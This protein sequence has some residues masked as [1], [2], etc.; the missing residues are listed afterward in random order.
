[1]NLRIVS[2]LFLLSGIFTAC[3][4]KSGLKSG[5]IILTDKEAFGKVIE[6]KGEK[7]LTDSMMDPRVRG[8]L[9]KDGKLIC[10]YEADPPFL[11][12]NAPS[13]KFEGYKGR[14]GNGPNEFV[15]PRLV[16]ASELDLLCY[17]YELTNQKVYILDNRYNIKPYPI[18]LSELF[19]DNRLTNNQLFNIRKDDFMFIKMLYNGISIFRIAKNG[20]SFQAK[21]LHS[22]NL[23]PEESYESIV[24][25]IEIIR[26]KY[27]EYYDNYVNYNAVLHN[28]SSFGEVFSFI[29]ENFGKEPRI[30]ELNTNAIVAGKEKEFYE[31]FISKSESYD[32]ST[33]AKEPENEIFNDSK[34]IIFDGFI[35]CFCGNSFDSFKDLFFYKKA[36]NYIPTG[37]CQPFQRKIFLTVNGK[38]LPCEKIG[39]DLPLGYVSDEKVIIDVEQVASI[40]SEMYSNIVNQC[41]SCFLWRNCGKCIYFMK[42]ENGKLKC[43]YFS[44]TNYA[45]SY[46]SNNISYAEENPIIYEKLY[47]EVIND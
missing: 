26:N 46:L 39:H 31:M 29:T 45:S 15:L 25:N 5:E 3:H 30:A 11:I 17:L 13:M 12:I 37:T 6:L 19:N 44:G 14:R 8:M 20:E 38:I 27:P 4:E 7:A 40:Y 28:R 34:A 36:K 47:N 1:M 23:K 43:Q 32:T 10:Q 24:K 18:K 22:L 41:K 2:Y 9:L 35:D 16:P 42:K 33:F 21:E